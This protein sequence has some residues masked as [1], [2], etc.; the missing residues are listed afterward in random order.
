MWEGG[1]ACICSSAALFSRHLQLCA[2]LEALKAHTL[3]IFM[4]TRWHSRDWTL[5]FHFQPFS[6]FKRMEGRRHW[7][8][9]ASKHGFSV[10]W[11]APTWSHPGAHPESPHEVTDRE[12]AVW[13]RWSCRRS[14]NRQMSQME[15][16]SG[17]GDLVYGGE[18]HGHGL[19]SRRA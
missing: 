13:G 14:R 17:F 2:N 16:R 8:F 15:V 12:R 3:G 10:W 1:K 18:G 7:N 6:L 11:P 9:Q 19:G 5:L 4:A